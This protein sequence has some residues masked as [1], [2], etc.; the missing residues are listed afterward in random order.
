MRKQA[1]W[2]RARQLALEEPSQLP[3]LPGAQI[4]I[5]WDFEAA[6]G[7]TWTVLRH[8]GA[9]IWRELAYY[10]GAPRFAEVFEILRARYG[11]RLT[12][13]RPTPASWTYLYG[14]DLRSPAKIDS[15]N[16]SLKRD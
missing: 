7:E 13:V 5:D 3:D 2:S 8:N 15:L 14:D 4:R 6:D 16:D 9:E 11:T 12:E 10:E 1:R